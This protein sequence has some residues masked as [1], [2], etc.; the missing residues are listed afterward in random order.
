[1]GPRHQL[2]E[3]LNAGSDSPLAVSR[4]GSDSPLCREPLG[5]CL[6]ALP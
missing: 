2:V 4:S 1:M 3:Q 6:S 5:L